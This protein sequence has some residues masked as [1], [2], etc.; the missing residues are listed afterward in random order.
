MSLTLRQSYVNMDILDRR[1]SSHH[2][3]SWRWSRLQVRISSHTC[4]TEILT[5]RLSA[6]IT[7]IADNSTHLRGLHGC[8]GERPSISVRFGG[9][10]Y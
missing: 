7:H 9:V 10:R 8:V 2:G 4:K 1:R 3:S 6:L 5:R